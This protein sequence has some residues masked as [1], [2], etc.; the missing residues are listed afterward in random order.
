MSRLTGNVPIRKDYAIDGLNLF[1]RYPFLGVGIGSN[2]GKALLIFLLS[3]IGIL[4]TGSFMLFCF[5][6]FKKMLRNIR[7]QAKNCGS[8]GLSLGLLLSFV[9]VFVGVMATEGWASGTTNIM[10]FFLAAMEGVVIQSSLK[11]KNYF[12]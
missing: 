5:L 1:L 10:W 12:T 8:R 6:L 2:K 4:G 11:Q 3:N 7:E 9:G